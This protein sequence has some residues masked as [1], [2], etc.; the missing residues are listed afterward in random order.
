LNT[1]H[2]HIKGRVQGVGFRPFVYKIAHELQLKGWVCNTTDGVHI[3]CSAEEELAN[4][5]Y[6]KCIYHKP[7]LAVITDSSIEKVESETFDNF[8]IIE[9]K[10]SRLELSLTPDF[11]ICKD[12]RYELA[13]PTNRRYRYPFIT[14]THCGPRY[15][16]LT[17]L[18]Y[19]RPYTSMESFEMCESCSKEYTDPFDRRYFSQ[20]N[21][22]Q[23]CGVKL[24]LIDPTQGKINLK[25]EEI[26]SRINEALRDE[27]IIAVKGIGGFLLLC[28]AT[29]DHAVK[30]LRE[31]KK[32]PSKPFAVLFQNTASVE[33]QFQI[34]EIEKELLEGASSPIILLTKK[35]TISP[36][37]KHIAPGLETIGVMLPYA[38]LLELISLQFNGPLVATSANISGAPIVYGEELEGLFQIADF[39]VD[40]NRVITFPQDDSVV[41]LSSKKKHKII[42]RRS[43]GMAPSVF[44]Q[45]ENTQVD[46]LALG[47]EMKAAFG[48]LVNSNTYISQYLGN[49]G[50][51]E[52]Q[53]QFERV[54]SGFK[55]LI[56]PDLEEIIVDMH[57][58][59]FTHQL[60]KELAA[61]ENLSLTEVQHHEAHFMS[62]LTERNLLDQRVLGIVWDG[63]G[64]G[65]DGNIWGGEF[66]E[67]ESQ[68]IQRIA[69]LDYFTHL[70]NDRMSIDNRLCALSLAGSHRE[71]LAHY[72]TATEWDFYSKS[73]VERQI[74]TSSMGR[75]FDAVAFI[76]G[77]AS[78]NTY[79]GHS[80]MLLEQEARKASFNVDQFDPYQFAISGTQISLS[81]AF[82][83]MFLDKVK[84][85]E[86]ISSRFH[87]TLVEIVRSIAEEGNY[88]KIAFSGGVFQN[89][90]LVDLLIDRLDKDFQLHFHEELSP[91]DENIAYG[92]LSYASCIKKTKKHNLKKLETCV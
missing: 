19:D 34:G 33:S 51:Y 15:S 47:A 48:F 1:Y 24:Y 57:P 55:N 43:R 92:Q 54:L 85:P 45:I 13:D 53:V 76:A 5:F 11:S 74:L 12:C 52:N 64:F 66:F 42:L 21:S 7:Q 61:K 72:F 88:H 44:K 56:Q 26:F 73:I 3:R 8:E 62:I 39:I 68:T 71:K 16:V 9:S 27:K 41:Q 31:R 22:C 91:N 60:G 29:S 40:H 30:T 6:Q 83:E 35:D 75:V 87:L 25:E 36:L 14:C 18:P 86:I 50:Y 65:S 81:K 82:D 80:A 10:D 67:Y 89:G 49:L 77:L 46:R 32:R 20:T 79:E 38:P 90:F 17:G 23:T 37:S 78:E 4:Q 28:N 63:T 69:H 70:A 58:G 2:I 59:Y 84:R